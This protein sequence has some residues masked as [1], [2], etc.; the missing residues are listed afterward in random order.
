MQ[1]YIKRD[2]TDVADSNAA[3]ED[4][5][6]AQSRAQNCTERPVVRFTAMLLLKAESV[7]HPVNNSTDHSSNV[8]QQQQ[9]QQEQIQQGQQQE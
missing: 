5:G 3:T 9:Q 1:T 4:K 6:A 7:Q 8:Q 2:E